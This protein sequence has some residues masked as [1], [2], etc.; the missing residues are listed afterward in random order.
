VIYEQSSSASPVI[1]NGLVDIVKTTISELTGTAKPAET[2]KDGKKPAENG[3]QVP[4]GLSSAFK[5]LFATDN[6]VK[7]V[8]DG[9]TSAASLLLSSLESKMTVSSSL[10]KKVQFVAPGL[11]CATY[12]STSK[13]SYTGGNLIETKSLDYSLSCGAMYLVTSE[14]LMKVISSLTMYKQISDSFKTQLD[15]A[16]QTLHGFVTALEDAAFFGNVFGFSDDDYKDKL[17]NLKNPVMVA[18]VNNFWRSMKDKSEDVRV[19]AWNKTFAEGTGLD[20]QITVC[21]HAYEEAYQALLKYYH[22]FVLNPPLAR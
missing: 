18:V 19:S 10:V 15:Q 3:T 20:K 11:Y 13:Y 22:E 9:V 21:Q 16:E 4:G 1:L 14:K 17:K 6:A 7:A 2:D 5:T 8:C 12:Y